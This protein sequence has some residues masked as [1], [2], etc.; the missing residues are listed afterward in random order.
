[1]P[2]K[3]LVQRPWGSYNKIFQE[4][5]VWVKRVEVAPGERISLQKH[6]HRSEK[7]IIVSGQGLVTV[8][9]LTVTV[10]KSSIIDIPVGVIHRIANLGKKPLVFIEVACGNDLTEVDIVRFEDDYKRVK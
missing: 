9:E 2:K 5:E 4:D 7:W 3:T 1:M 6:A 10:S 8:N